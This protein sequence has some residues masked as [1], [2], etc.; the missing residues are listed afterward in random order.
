MPFY[1]LKNLPDRDSYLVGVPGS[2]LLAYLPKKE[3]FKKY[4]VGNTGFASISRIEANKISLS[5]Q[6]PHYIRRILEYLLQPVFSAQQMRIKHV[7]RVPHVFCKVAI[8]TE[9]AKSGD[10]FAS[11]KESMNGSMTD[12]FTDTICFVKFSSDKKEYIMN[13]L[14]PAPRERIVNV[15]YLKELETAQVYVE[16]DHIRHFMGKRGLNVATAS[17]LVGVQI[18]LFGV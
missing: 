8:V 13:A 3:A 15:I 4:V 18:N 14:A 1:V 17:R 9:A 6:S 12:F 5:Q 2:G 7:A 16:K 10:I 11:C